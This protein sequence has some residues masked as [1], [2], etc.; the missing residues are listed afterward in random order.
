MLFDY[1]SKLLVY[2]QMDF[3]GRTDQHGML[4][5]TD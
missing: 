2:S 4:M 1:F 3:Y 5:A